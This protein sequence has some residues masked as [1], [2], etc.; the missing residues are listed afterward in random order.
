MPRVSVKKQTSEKT[1]VK[2]NTAIKSLTSKKKKVEKA[3][4]SDYAKSDFKSISL[5]DLK[6]KT[7]RIARKNKQIKETTVELP[8]EVTN[9]ML[10]KVALEKK[11]F[12]TKAKKTAESIAIYSGYSFVVLGLYLY[13]T[14]SIENNNHINQSLLATT[15]CSD[16]SCLSST[17]DTTSFGT[18]S[19]TVDLSSKIVPTFSFKTD[20]P[21]NIKED[22]YVTL[23]VT[24]TK[25]VELYATAI[26]LGEDI[27]L[28]QKSVEGNTHI[29]IVPY[30]HLHSALYQLRLRVLSVDGTRYYFEGPS[31]SILKDE[32]VSTT[33]TT[34]IVIETSASTTVATTTTDIKT[35]KPYLNLEEIPLS[36]KIK[37]I[38]NNASDFSRAEIYAFPAL[39]ST[40]IFLGRATK[41]ENIWVFY[42]DKKTLPIGNYS[43]FSKVIKDGNTTKTAPISVYIKPTPIVKDTAVS[44]SETPEITEPLILTEKVESAVVEYKN[45]NPDT[46]KDLIEQREVY[47]EKDNSNTTNQTESQ[48]NTTPTIIGIDKISEE[49]MDSERE[50]INLLLQRYASSLQ[51]DDDNIK[52]LALDELYKLKDSLILKAKTQT[53]TKDIS[54]SIA[55]TLNEKFSSLIEKVDKYENLL[56]ERTELIGRDTDSD[57]I[58]DFDEVNLYKTDP[59]LTDT[60]NDGI[61]DSIEITKG[62]NPLNPD[63]EAIINFASPKDVNYI[64]SEKMIVESVKPVIEINK[65]NEKAP[66]LAEIKGKALP[67]SFVTLYIYSSPT[68]VTIKTDS[69]GNFVYTLTKELEDGE[70]EVYV[71]MTDNEGNIVV[72]SN[73]FQFVKTAEAFTAMDTKEG[74]VILTNDA[75][76]DTQLNSYNITATMGVVSFG[77]ILLMLGYTLRNRPEVPNSETE[78]HDSGS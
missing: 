72:R 26:S 67:N 24:D 54:E 59:N 42:L 10:K 69:D 39:S 8:K 48:D 5:I 52:R 36:E 53:N 1:V 35:D 63:T 75:Y 11:L 32:P 60:D 55:I 14:V 4:K 65:D 62:F 47:F 38:V 70:H 33:T 68:I 66:V 30:D 20:I 58:T 3:V 25:E 49:L 19:T 16:T 51:G 57:G 76:S 9:L 34:D 74:D 21:S 56:K 41:S 17:T 43:V 31:F 6:P 46:E 7:R 64:D 44:T 15:A 37:F 29:F 77:L 61:I 27:K 45:E 2:K 71:A 73:P 28:N 23:E 40:P 12:S 78:Q 50:E 18:L 13:F 22:F